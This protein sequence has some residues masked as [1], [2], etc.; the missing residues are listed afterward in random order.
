MPVLL[1]VGY[2]GIVLLVIDA[3]IFRLTINPI[4][5][6]SSYV[7]PPVPLVPLKGSCVLKVK[8]VAGHVAPPT[9]SYVLIIQIVLRWKSVIETTPSNVNLV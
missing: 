7:N 5:T 9:L 1:L 4:L 6:P 3:K 8:I 2:M